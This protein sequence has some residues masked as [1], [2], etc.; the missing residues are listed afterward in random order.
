MHSQLPP[1]EDENR[2]SISCLNL[3][4]S[5]KSRSTT[6]KKDEVTDPLV[7]VEFKGE[8]SSPTAVS[9]LPV[10]VAKIIVS[11]LSLI[12]LCSHRL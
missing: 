7:L 5:I 3:H 10:C 2:V 8:N 11:V 12:N 1:C 6:V 4:Y 9:M